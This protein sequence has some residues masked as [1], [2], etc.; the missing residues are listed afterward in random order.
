LLLCG[1]QKGSP[2]FLNNS[3]CEKMGNLYCPCNGRFS[4]PGTVDLIHFFWYFIKIVFK[5]I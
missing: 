4:T 3:Y 2:I 5:T 1:K